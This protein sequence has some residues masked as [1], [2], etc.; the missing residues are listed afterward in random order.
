MHADVPAGGL[1]LW[2]DGDLLG[3]NRRWAT[4]QQVLPWYGGRDL[5]VTRRQRCPA[6]RGSQRILAGNLSASKERVWPRSP[7]LPGYA[8][9]RC[10]S[11]YFFIVV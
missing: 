11:Y 1:W 3:W 6:L 4:I 9:D 8:N 2:L 5:S 7:L 10:I